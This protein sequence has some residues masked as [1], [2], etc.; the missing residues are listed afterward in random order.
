MTDRQEFLL[1]YKSATI[2]IRKGAYVVSIVWQENCTYIPRTTIPTDEEEN[3][4]F[5]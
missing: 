3:D 4:A 5:H 1:R 2:G